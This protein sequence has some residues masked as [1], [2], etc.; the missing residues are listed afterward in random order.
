MRTTIGLLAL[1]SMLVP[2]M[3]E[4]LDQRRTLLL[5]DEWMAR[6]VI[7][8]LE[9]DAKNPRKSRGVGSVHFLNGLD[10]AAIVVRRTERRGGTRVRYRVKAAK[11]SGIRVRSAC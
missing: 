11:S 5:P 1:V 10:D 7:E 4:D 2:A 9:P 6:V 8:P 3:A